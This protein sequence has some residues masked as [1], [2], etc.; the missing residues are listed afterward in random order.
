MIFDTHAHYDDEAFDID[1]EELLGSMRENNV[2]YIV[3][4]GAS[5]QGVLDTVSLMEKYDL[6]YGALGIHPDH[7][8]DLTEKEME[9]LHALLQKEK[10]VAVGEIGLDYYWDKASHE[11]QKKWFAEQLHLASEL[12]LPINVHSREASQ[13]SFDLICAEHAKRPGF[14]GGIIH[15]YSGSPEMAR[16]YVKRGYHIGIGGVV[17]FKNARVLKEVAAQIPLEAIVVE[18]DCPYLA[19]TPYR[20]KRNSSLFIPYIIEE[21]A[22]IKEV[23]PQ[24]VEMATYRNACRVYNIQE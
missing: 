22:R 14:R 8:G 3:N 11:V 18:T 9:Q 21:I 15:C 24:E 7:A 2:Q 5:M 10:A 23:P 19:P 20:G 12:E 4:V 6:V 13:D 1:R 17:T 16:E